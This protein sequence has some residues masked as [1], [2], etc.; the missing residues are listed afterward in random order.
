[1]DPSD[2]FS[3]VISPLFH[4]EWLQFVGNGVFLRSKEWSRPTIPLRYKG[5][6][7]LHSAI[8]AVSGELN[9][10]CWSSGRQADIIRA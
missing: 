5:L 7:E 10:R 4:W 8:F 9:D 6:K 2:I 3:W 1:M